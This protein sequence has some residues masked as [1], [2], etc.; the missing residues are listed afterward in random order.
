MMMARIP[1][2]WLTG[3]IL[4]FALTA[5]SAVDRGDDFAEAQTLG[6]ATLT[7]LW[8]ASPGWAGVRSDGEPGGVTVELMR[9]FARWLEQEQGLQVNLDWIEEDNW[10]RFYGRVRDGRGGVFGLGNV[11]ITEARRAELQF[12]PPYARN[13]GVLITPAFAP[14]LEPNASLAER[15]RGLR[16]LAFVDT[17]HEQRLRELAETYWPD[18]PMDFTRSNEEILE[19]VAAG[20]HFAY[21]DGY[22]Y[23]RVA[24]AAPLRRQANFDAADERFGV[25]MPLDNDWAPLLERYFSEGPGGLVGSDWY[26][27]LLER[28]LGSETAELMRVRPGD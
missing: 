16:A 28:K 6:S 8:V 12:S 19:S 15:L 9:G 20:T 13:L 27:D 21:I 5:A 1:L 10:S 26:R 22:H 17:L 3:F 14:E 11:T 4:A 18:M 23:L 24:A 2:S 7:V 25:I